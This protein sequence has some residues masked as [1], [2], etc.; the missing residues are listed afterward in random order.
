MELSV[1][2]ATRPNIVFILA[3]DLSY[4]DLGCFGQ[5]QFATPNLDR[6][7]RHGLRFDE[8][9]AASPE[10]AP[11]RC[12]IMT[13]MHMGHSRIRSNQ[14]AR[15]QDHLLASDVTIAE[16][17]KGEGYAT[18]MVGKWG[19][20]LPGT[21]GTPDKKGFDYSYGF[22]DQGRAH[23]YYPH[24]LMENG[25]AVRLPENH[26]FDMTWSYRHTREAECPHM[27]DADG[28]LVP[29]GVDEPMRAKNSAVL[30]QQKALQFI[31]HHRNEPFFLYYATQLPHGPVIAPYLGHLKD[32][33]WSQK[34]KEWAAM[35]R[36][37]D[38][39]VDQMVERLKK[40]GILNNTILVF[41]SDN[42]YAHW[43]YMGRPRYD[44]D[45]LFRNKGPWKGG[46][47]I[48]W[49]GGVRAPMFV[50]WFD[51]IRAGATRFV[52]A[53]YDLFATFADLAGSAAP[54]ETDGISL[55]PLLGGE[56]DR[57]PHHKYLYW[58]N[59]TH[60]PRGQSARFGQYFTWRDDPGSPIQVYD[61]TVDAENTHD[62]ARE[63]PHLA[64]RARGIYDEAHE[65][66]LWNR[67][68]TES[69]SEFE[70]KRNRAAADGLLQITTRPNTR[71][72]MP[73]GSFTDAPLI[74]GDPGIPD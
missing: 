15:G 62:L 34:H 7:C 24:Y 19:I 56:V 17:L 21:E 36:L 43:G 53:Q 48:S 30:C 74:S 8:A 72:L 55:A 3:D 32:K 54:S 61:T 9:Y 71:Y 31:D 38:E 2:S 39:Y 70:A 51:R 68:P 44:D 41:A 5:I 58:E 57:Q 4:R 28:V 66:S 37:L 14:S 40:Y 23:T 49:E 64:S 18:G 35:I 47:F 12:G 63:H 69:D 26:G 60:A 59:G 25:H 6:L 22:Y 52:T 29:R 67:N 11:A 33:P 20:G 1:L 27:Y 46:K 73:D 10:C 45:P 42:G 65:D 16:V 50:T 13:G